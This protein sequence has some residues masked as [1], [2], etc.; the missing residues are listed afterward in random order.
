MTQITNENFIHV[1]TEECNKQSSSQECIG[2]LEDLSLQ[3]S[4]HG[5]QVKTPIFHSVFQG[6]RSDYIFYKLLPKGLASSTDLGSSCDPP[7]SQWALA[8]TFP[9]GSIQQWKSL[10]AS[11]WK[12][13]I[14]ISIPQAFMPPI[15][16]TAPQN[17]RLLQPTK[18]VFTSPTG[19]WVLFIVK[20][21]SS[22]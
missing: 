10:L 17:T 21:I 19:Q 7:Q 16:G 14:H 13:H 22:F 18:L 2:V 15:W 11:L 5:K 12:E 6:K 3:S 9:C 20:K 8:L 4:V 1:V